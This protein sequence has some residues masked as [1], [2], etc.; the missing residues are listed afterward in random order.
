M[1]ST[2][3]VCM[4]VGDRILTTNLGDTRT[5][6]CR[7]GIAMNLSEDHKPDVQSELARITNLGGFVSNGRILGLISVSRSFGDF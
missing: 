1:G 4:I 5:V 2:A 6:L 3:N 7:N